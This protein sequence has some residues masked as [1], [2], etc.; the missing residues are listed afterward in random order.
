MVILIVDDDKGIR[1]LTKSIL[2]D[3]GF[4]VITASHG[5][6]AL[7]ILAANKRIELLISDEFMPHLSGT[8]LIDS[9][10]HKRP[11]MK[12]IIFSGHLD[13]KILT[14]KLIQKNIPFLPKPFTANELV[15]KVSHVLSQADARLINQA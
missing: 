13:D 6:E 9:I 7:E 14:A 11:N 3:R 5:G 4:K 12:F 15:D 1:E 10:A 2:E 8:E